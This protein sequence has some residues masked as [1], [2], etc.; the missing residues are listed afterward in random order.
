MQATDSFSVARRA[1]D[2]EDFV[3]IARRH[4]TWIFGPLWAGIVI[5]TVV[6]FLWPDTY[7]SSALIR[8]SASQVPDRFVSSNINQVLAERLNSITQEVLS[9][10]TLTNV[11][12]THDLYPK[13]RRR[14]PMDDVIENMRTK[15]KIGRIDIQPGTGQSR[16]GAFPI[17]F[18]YEN[19]YVAQ[20]VVA[21]IV[22]KV[23]NENERTTITISQTTTD[24]LTAEVN[25]A[26]L[27]LDE[28]E[29]KMSDFRSRNMT[30]L[31]DTQMANLSALTSL[32]QRL[33]Q[34]NSTA[35]RINQDR[36]LMESN[37]RIQREQLAKGLEAASV[38]SDPVRQHQR[39]EDLVRK[40]REIAAAEQQLTQLR[41]L[42]T[43]EHPEIKRAES[44]LDAAKKQRD[45]LE[46]QD[47]ATRK[48][49]QTDMAKAP[50]RIVYTKELQAME[51]NVKQLE[52]MIQAKA[53]EAQE[54]AAELGRTNSQIQ[55]VQA[56]IMSS[57]AAQHQFTQLSR[58]LENAR[59]SYNALQQKQQESDRGTKIIRNKQG[60]S[61]DLLD[62]ASLPVTPAEPKRPVIIGAGAIIG[63]IL[64]AV[65]VGVREMKDT[66]LKNL[67]DVRAYTQLTVLGSIPLIE[68]DIVVKRRKRLGLLGWLTALVVGVLVMGGSI[69]YYVVTTS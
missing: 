62:P 61:L 41:Q 33:S 23:M 40:E 59:L 21:D 66:T 55:G 64:G 47:E 52:S 7:V 18:S 35:S 37:L 31:P 20:K 15:I 28:I 50:R 24:F 51:A 65:L 1:P 60:E 5:S 34:L 38:L 43:R 10:S 14:L 22:S 11:I 69:V 39:S 49:L 27:K 29:A 4:R 48:A 26:K 44:L 68:D 19:R 32:D 57:P 63:L 54:I 53:L 42:W 45:E 12:Q 9:R 58:D 30:A 25:Q 17:T 16:V 46:R 2:F 3:D 8:I 13:E 6:A 36:L 67:K 56:R